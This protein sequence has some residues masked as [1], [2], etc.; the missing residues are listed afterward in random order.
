VVLA[1]FVDFVVIAKVA[2]IA[3]FP[4]VAGVGVEKRV[5]TSAVR[6][7]DA[8]VASLRHDG[9]GLNEWFQGEHREKQSDDRKDRLCIKV[10][11][12]V[13]ASNQF[14]ADCGTSH[15]WSTFEADSAA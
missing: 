6:E 14:S 7:L 9:L 10:N 11:A 13:S 4:N 15:S 2:V 5:I 12:H 1:K 3:I 8:S